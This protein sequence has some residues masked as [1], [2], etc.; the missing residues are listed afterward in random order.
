MSEKTRVRKSFLRSD[1]KSMIHKEQFTSSK[2]QTFALWKVLLGEWK[3]KLQ[4]GKKICE[5]IYL[6]KI[7]EIIYSFQNIDIFKNST[8]RNQTTQF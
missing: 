3:Y 7:C 2:L 1:T 8:V 6:T 5:I 4:T